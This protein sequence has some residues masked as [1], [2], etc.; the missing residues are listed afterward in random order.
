MTCRRFLHAGLA[1]ICAACGADGPVAPWA[2]GP[3]TALQAA[4]SVP[5]ELEGVW[6][7]TRADHLTFPPFAARAVFGVEPEGRTTVATCLTQGT[8]E[9]SQEGA[10]VSGDEVTD[11][12]VCHTL[13]GQ[14]FALGPAAHVTGEIV[15]RSVHM[16]FQGMVRCL[17]HAVGRDLRGDAP[18]RLVGGGRCVIPGHPRS[19]VP[20]F[21]PP[22]AGTEVITSWQAVRS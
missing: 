13:G 15:G 9:L 17:L 22:P 21:E 6:A 20:G 8:L 16:T 19:N 2:A 12:S 11:A 3:T 14:P 1:L 4:G 5:M 18:Q 7:W 10:V